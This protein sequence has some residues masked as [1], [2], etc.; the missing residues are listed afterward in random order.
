MN[1]KMSISQR[2]VL[3][4]IAILL[5]GI[6]VALD[7]KDDSEIIEMLEACEAVSETN[8]WSYT[9]DAAKYIQPK[10]LAIAKRR[11]MN[12]FSLSTHKAEPAG[13]ENK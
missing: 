8:C 2:R 9:H 4:P 12:Y 3:E 10:L 5:C 7:E 11:K 13:S 1:K 6:E